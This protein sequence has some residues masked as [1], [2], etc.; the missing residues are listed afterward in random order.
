MTPTLDDL[1]S[2]AWV[3]AGHGPM[4]IRNLSRVD[5]VFST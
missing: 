3:A 2:V 4:L 1:L 5:A